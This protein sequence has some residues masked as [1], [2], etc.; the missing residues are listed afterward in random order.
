MTVLANHNNTVSGT[1][2]VARNAIAERTELYEA[3]TTGLRAKF[4]QAKAAV[5][6][7]FSRRSP[8]DKSVSGIR[9]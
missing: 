9:S 7:Q 4:Q 6:S 8:E 3:Q 1:L 5:A 2:V